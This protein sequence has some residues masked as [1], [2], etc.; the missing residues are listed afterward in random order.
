MKLDD[1]SHDEAWNRLRRLMAADLVPFD[2]LKWS[3]SNLQ[4]LLRKLSHQ[5]VE[6]ALEEIQLDDDGTF[7]YQGLHVLVYIRDQKFYP[8]RPDGEYKFHICNCKTIEDFRKNNRLNRYVASRR[9]DGTFLVNVR[10]V[11]TGAYEKE[12][13]Y[14]KLNVCKYCLAQLSYKG[15][16]SYSTTPD[17]Y[18][19]FELAEFFDLYK[20]SQFNY[21][22]THS[23]YTSPLEEYSDTFK[24]LSFEIRQA[25]NW[26]CA[27]CNLS[28]VS[29]KNLLHVH[30]A[31]GIKSDNR[32]V[33][34]EPIC[35]GCHSNQPGHERLKFHPDFMAFQ[36]KYSSQWNAKKIQANLF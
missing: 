13:E 6:V 1:F 17:I 25:A 32:L 24:D 35:I 5:G 22:P 23:E 3:N 34:L 10:N 4:E 16:K 14:L 26:C 2:Q 8:N 7:T 11:V 30:H 9:T 15:Y 20:D 27:M 12:G 36:A 29:D 19:D 28:L 18:D 21:T 31:N 33:N